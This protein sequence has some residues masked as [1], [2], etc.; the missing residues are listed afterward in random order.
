MKTI[1]VTGSSG[2]IGKYLTGALLD[3]NYKVIEIDLDTGIDLTS[4]EEAEKIPPFDAIVHLAGRSFVPDSFS[5]PWEFY[6]VNM[7]STLNVVELAR[8]Y[9][10]RALFFSSYLYG[11]P[12]YLP[13][14]EKHPLAPHNPYAQ[15]KL[16]CE[17]IC[18]G[19]A[20]DFDVPVIIFR[21]FNIYGPGQRD[22]F[23]IPDIINQLANEEIN[24]RDPRPKRDY[25]YITDV[26][27]AILAAIEYSKSPFEIFNIGYGQSHSVSEIAETILEL[28][29]VKCKVSYTEDVRKGEILD[30]VADITR[31]WNL[32][33][34]TPETGIREGLAKML[35]E[36]QS[37]G[38]QNLKPKT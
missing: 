23:I 19:Y 30:T 21:P 36:R 32:L 12:Q 13:I 34:W 10:A 3:E 2:F 1:A 20:R 29:H 26:I 18:E 27:K 22:S 8:K 4:R 28:S 9:K 37:A 5:K 38:T 11:V 7:L 14:D 33:G 6:R 17:K 31:A 15:S 35:Q 16:V 24:L 25:I